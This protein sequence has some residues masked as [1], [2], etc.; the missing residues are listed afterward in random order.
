MNNDPYL[1]E[2]DSCGKLAPEDE[3]ESILMFLGSREDGPDERQ[4]YCPACISREEEAMVNNCLARQDD[5][6]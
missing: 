4:A 3:M 5:Y 6:Y 1:I 2:C